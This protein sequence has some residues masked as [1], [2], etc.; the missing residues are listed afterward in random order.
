MAKQ[1]GVGIS[2]DGRDPW[3]AFAAYMRALVDADT[4]SMRLALAATFTPTPEM[5][6][7]AK[8]A[9]ELLEISFERIKGALR[10][11]VDVHELPGPPPT[12]PAL[13]QRWVT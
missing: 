9:N 12:W 8:R 4:S 5:F 11:D 3:P 7:L 13:N 6:A 2:A 10:P 1:A